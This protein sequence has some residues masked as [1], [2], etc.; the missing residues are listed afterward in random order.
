MNTR[1]IA[2]VAVLVLTGCAIA[3]TAREPKVTR[4]GGNT[5]VAP[6]SQPSQAALTMPPAIPTANNPVNAA[7]TGTLALASG[8]VVSYSKIISIQM[9]SIALATER[10]KVLV[11]A[12]SLSPEIQNTIKQVKRLGITVRGKL[13][14]LT[15]E[16]I[17]VR[18]GA[19]MAEREAN[20]VPQG[21]NMTGRT[22]TVWHQMEN[23][24]EF[25]V[26]TGFHDA[27]ASVVNG[28]QWKGMIYP[29]GSYSFTVPADNHHAEP[30]E[31]TRTCYAYTPEEAVLW[32]QN[33]P[34]KR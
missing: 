23:E 29:A 24:Q 4:M 34:D 30:Y 17:F 27:T 9:D 32:Q 11:A 13:E 26:L 3:K 18:D 7:T 6:S 5:D 15:A 8:R 12:Y 21:K 16:G 33:H 28:T 20:Y 14:K 31:R 2:V 19:R 10:G 22:E 1:R 25:F